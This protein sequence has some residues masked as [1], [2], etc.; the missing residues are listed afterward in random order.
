MLPWRF[1]P[2]W[3]EPAT[4]SAD[5]CRAYG[6]A[7]RLVDTAREQYFD[8]FAAIASEGRDFQHHSGQVS[9]LRKTVLSW[10]ARGETA[11]RERGDGRN[12][13]LWTTK[14]RLLC[15]WS[16]DGAGHERP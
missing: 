1:R 4:C 10:P 8:G 6:R 2:S 14:F 9:C 11:K 12:P 15:Q 16:N 5:N 3:D 13:A 7:G